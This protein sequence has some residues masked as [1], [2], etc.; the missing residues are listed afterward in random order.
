MATDNMARFLALD[1]TS[2][3]EACFRFALLKKHR[4]VFST[5]R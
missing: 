4:E 5:F 1:F 3:G 2:K